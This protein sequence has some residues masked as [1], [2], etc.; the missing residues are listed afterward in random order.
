[1]YNYGII[2]PTWNYTYN[3]TGLGIIICIIP[4]Y[5]SVDRLSSVDTRR[6]S[7]LCDDALE[8]LKLH[9][10]HE[11][12]L[13]RASPPPTPPITFPLIFSTTAL[14]YRLLATLDLSVSNRC[15]L[16]K[17]IQSCAPIKSS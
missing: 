14:P 16:R 12:T 8:A 5:G 3:Y 15:S 4:L 6:L 13:Q 7:W 2:I 9:N 17:R 11:S 10:V 1:M